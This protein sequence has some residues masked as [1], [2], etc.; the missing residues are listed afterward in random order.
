MNR[1]LLT[2]TAGFIGY[3]LTELLLKNGYHVTGLDCINEY[4][5]V[6]LKYSRLQRLGIS[7]EQISYNQLITV[8]PQQQFIQLRLEDKDA[9]IAL[10][11][12]QQFDYV[13]HLAA[14]AGV[15]YSLENPYTYIESNISGFLNILEGCRAQKVKHLI[16]ASSSSVYGLNQSFPFQRG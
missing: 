1:I 2:G 6:G 15:R 4:Y 9:M 12:S 3:H 11:A 13:I 14:Q 16:Y 8:S 5:E 10:F 7:R